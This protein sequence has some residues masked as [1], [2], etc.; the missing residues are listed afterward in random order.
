MSIS[1]PLY[2]GNPSGFGQGVVGAVNHEEIALYW[3]GNADAW[4]RHSRA[5]RDIY[6]DALNTPAFLA[7]L[8][9][10]AGLDGLDVGCGEGSNTRKLAG[11]GAKMRAIDISPTFIRNA[12]AVERADP[13]GVAFHLGDAARLPFREESFDFIT[14]FMCLM[15]VSDQAAAL[16]EAFRALR[17]AGF[18]Q[19][20]ILH[21]CFVPPYRKVVRD[22][23]G[24]PRALKLAGYFDRI[25]GR[26]DTWW[27]TALSQRER[28]Q[29]PPFRVPRFHR[30]LGEWVDMIVAAGLVLEKIVEPCADRETAA[31]EPIV[32][33]TRVAPI[34][35]LV[36]AR[37]PNSAAGR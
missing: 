17:P 11:L 36:R 28:E 25:D 10:P 12:Q 1:A 31:A 15:D 13:L 5:G 34:S 4:T 35:L 9:P 14:S 2:L 27:F 24:Q 7:M 16:R 33:D 37:K 8:P 22:P 30:T 21:P 29:E 23:D 26:V 20:S 19:F 18:L 3:E 6:R 32:A